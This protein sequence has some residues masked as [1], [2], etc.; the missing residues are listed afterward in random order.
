MNDIT[1]TL[2]KFWKQNRLVIIILAIYFC[3]FFVHTASQYFQAIQLEGEWSI[4]DSQ[5]YLHGKNNPDGFRLEVPMSWQSGVYD[6]G[7]PKNLGDARAAF[8][9]PFFV[10]TPKIYTY[11]WWRRIDDTWELETVRDWFIDNLG[12][13]INQTVLEQERNSFRSTTVGDGNYPALEHEF[14]IAGNQKERVVIVIVDDEA[15]VLTFTSKWVDP[16]TDKIFNR[17]LDSFEVYQ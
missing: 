17:M 7:G 14:R 3:G 2:A 12:Y 11:V 16:K 15:F 13:G 5:E 1:P 10:F 6:N 8:D 9:E 4:F